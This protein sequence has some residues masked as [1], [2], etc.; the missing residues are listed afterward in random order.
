MTNA[1]EI[2]YSAFLAIEHELDEGA[3]GDGRTPDGRLFWIRRYT[4]RVTGKVYDL[5]FAR[6]DMEPRCIEMPKPEV[7]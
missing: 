1:V 5:V 6:G 4:S 7:S 3:I 2:P